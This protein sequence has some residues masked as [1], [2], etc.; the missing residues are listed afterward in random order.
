[1]RQAD[2][3]QRHIDSVPERDARR[4]GGIG[5]EG[6]AGAGGRQVGRMDEV[7]RAP[8][9]LGRE[10]HELVH[11]EMRQVLLHPAGRRDGEHARHRRQT[12]IEHG[13]NRPAP[14]D[15]HDR[16]DPEPGREQEFADGRG[17]RRQR[18][19]GRRLDDPR[20]PKPEPLCERRGEIVGGHQLGNL[21]ADD[22]VGARPL[23][24][25]RD[26]CGRHADALGDIHL[27]HARLV[28]HPRHAVQQR[29]GSRRVGRWGLRHVAIPF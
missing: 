28:V 29:A 23:Q 7:R 3:H 12:G 24:Q 6:L 18:R 9:L 11:L 22:S 26:G 10:A 14:A 27:A 20:R 25:A 2:A 19:R 21:D 13:A 8:H 5:E 15:R 1:M 4:D 16:A 17:Q